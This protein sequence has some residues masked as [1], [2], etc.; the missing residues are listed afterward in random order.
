LFAFLLT[1]RVLFLFVSNFIIKL[2]A[3][4]GDLVSEKK[5][6]INN[7]MIMN[8][9]NKIFYESWEFFYEKGYWD[10]WVNGLYFYH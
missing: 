5:I 8:V 9:L 7:K 1:L 3:I 6:D 10:F 2:K 4:M